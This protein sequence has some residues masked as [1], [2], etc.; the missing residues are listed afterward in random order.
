MGSVDKNY[1]G[2]GIQTFQHLK[3]N[4]YACLGPYIKT[5][6]EG[7]ASWHPSVLGHRL[8]GSHHAYFWLLIWYEA[9]KEVTSL[10]VHRSLEA[11]LKDVEH[12]Q[13]TLYPPLHPAVH[14]SVMLDDMKCYTD[15]E[16]RSVREVS[17]KNRVV[18]GL[19]SDE[20]EKGDH[21]LLNIDTTN[22]AQGG[23][24]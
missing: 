20:K 21:Q 14:K 1:H 4:E 7:A 19:A 6:G 18:G 5:W 12:H 11:I 3:H 16:P 24:L 23:I 10:A 17:L 9:L 8:R 22:R 15:Y 13:A 2:A